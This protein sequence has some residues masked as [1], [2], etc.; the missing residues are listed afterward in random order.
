M[1]RR[2]FSVDWQHWMAPVEHTLAGAVTVGPG[3]VAVTVTVTVGLL[4]MAAAREMR[5]RSGRVPK[6]TRMAGWL[7]VWGEGNL[8]CTALRISLTTSPPSFCTRAN[9]VFCVSL[10][11]DVVSIA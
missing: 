11:S 2:T 8:L 5:D 4:G 3:A 6:Q 7:F 1:N 9:S 10:H